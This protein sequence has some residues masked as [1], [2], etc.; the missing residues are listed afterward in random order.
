MT[1]IPIILIVV[2]LGWGAWLFYDARDLIRLGVSSCWWPRTEGTIIDSR[3]NSFTIPGLDNT[4]SGIVPVRYE[5]RVHE[6]MCEVGGG[7]YQCST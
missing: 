3:D 1:A 5:E 6:Y 4:G 7:Q 2:L